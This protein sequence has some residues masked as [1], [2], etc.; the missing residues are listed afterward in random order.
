MTTQLASVN[1][2]PNPEEQLLID[3]IRT[4]IEQ[5]K[6][7]AYYSV[8]NEKKTTYWK[9]GKHLKKHLLINKNR[10]NYGDYLFGLLA[11][12]LEIN[13]RTLYQSAQFYEEY[14]QKILNARSKLTWSHYRELMAVSDKEKRVLLEEKVLAENL[15]TRDLIKLIHPH[16]LMN[17]NNS[18]LILNVQRTSPYVYKYTQINGIDMVDLGFN[19]KIELP[20]CSKKTSATA[21]T[22][23]GAVPHYTYK[24][25]VVEVLDGDTVWVHID[26]G[27]KG[28]TTQKLRLRG[29]NSAEIITSE[30]KTAKAHMISVLNPCQFVAIKTYWRD[31]FARYLADIFYDTHETDLALLVQNGKFL[32]QELLDEGYAVRYE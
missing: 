26:L 8:Q 2:L 20:V 28:W 1:T 13:Q 27:M 5:G 17:G 11:E 9:V 25:F 29:V 4:E 30:G 22:H 31:K 12:N 15:S 7:N 21:V 24:A 6:Q 19:F 14:P 3:T 10:A 16:K 23:L 32:N 18:D